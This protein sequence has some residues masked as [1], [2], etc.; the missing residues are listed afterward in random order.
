MSS[1]SKISNE[2][3][4][5]PVPN[6]S[7][8]KQTK[9]EEGDNAGKVV[10]GQKVI[11]KPQNVIHTI[12]DV[13]GKDDNVNRVKNIADTDITDKWSFDA[14]PLQ[15]VIDLG[16]PAK[17]IDYVRIC[18][19]N[20]Q[21]YTLEFSNDNTLNGYS[22]AQKGKLKRGLNDIKTASDLVARYA[23]FTFP[24]NKEVDEDKNQKP[25]PL[26]I[27]YV[28]FGSGEINTSKPL[29]EPGPIV[30]TE[31]EGPKEP[32]KPTEGR[33]KDWGADITKGADKWKIVQ[34]KQ[35]QKLYKVTDE[36][37]VNIADLFTTPQNA[38]VFVAWHQ[39]KQGKEPAPPNPE[40]P[41][42]VDPNPNPQ[43]GGSGTDKF[44]TE[45][46]YADGKTIVYEYKNNFRDDGKRFD[47][48]VG[49]W[50][51]SEATAYFRFT[52]NPVDDEISIKWSEK[53][54]S[55]S[56]AV[57]CYDTG[58]NIKN[59]KARMRFENPHPNYSGNLGSGQGTPQ[60]TKFIG[61]KGVKIPQANGS[62]LVE[63]YQ[64]TGDNEGAKPANQWKKI[65][66]YTDSKYKRTGAH[67]HITFR[68]DNPAKKGQ[69][70][71]EIKWVSVARIA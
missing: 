60:G 42:P 17:E 45:L 21:E 39:W 30:P 46:K 13:F 41:G 28:Q 56:N 27:Y 58:V 67:P 33:I 7:V 50:K 64:D 68:V 2:E 66:S 48:N 34:M 54:H 57:Q 55:S 12:R 16:D 69:K 44:G 9:E 1:N 61:Y 24:G 53:S 43:P 15:A 29:P 40:P 31:P 51:A 4:T 10:G 49:D 70:N 22:K 6:P 18:S 63:L 8:D 25:D 71:L 62:V 65:Y 5:K 14:Y 38:Q 26:G 20:E 35:G 3:S 11:A 19:E 47:M 23:R 36:K 59:G 32:P 37:G 52:Q